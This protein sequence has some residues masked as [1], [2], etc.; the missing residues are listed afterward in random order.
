MRT[1]LMSC[2]LQTMS[3]ELN[4][5]VMHA[6][7]HVL[8]RKLQCHAIK[9]EIRCRIIKIMR[10]QNRVPLWSTCNSTFRTMKTPFFG[11]K[12]SQGSF[13]TFRHPIDL[14]EISGFKKRIA[15]NGHPS[16]ELW[17]CKVCDH[18]CRR[19]QRSVSLCVS[20][21]IRVFNSPSPLSRKIL[22]KQVLTLL[23]W[24]GELKVKP[25]EVLENRLLQHQNSLL[26][27]AG[28]L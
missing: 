9:T 15:P 25:L 14:D 23:V 5:S 10:L 16:A 27:L 28:L 26:L 20:P 7:I 4:C 18:R 19:F 1:V 21:G 3:C 24:L 12:Y 2:T 22:W 11:P 17:P 8:W 6:S 13:G